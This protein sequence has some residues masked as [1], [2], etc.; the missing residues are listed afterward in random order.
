MRC[1]HNKGNSQSRLAGIP[2]A[3]LLLATRLAAKQGLLSRDPGRTSSCAR[4]EGGWT[5][6]PNHRGRKCVWD[7]RGR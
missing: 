7:K 4:R 2:S 5:E 1:R 3:D 6:A